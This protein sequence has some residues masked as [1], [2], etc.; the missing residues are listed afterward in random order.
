MDPK[1]AK[2]YY[3]IRSPQA[4]DKAL[5]DLFDSETG[6]WIRKEI[7]LVRSLNRSILLIFL[8]HRVELPCGTLSLGR[9]RSSGT[10]RDCRANISWT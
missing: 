2:A 1:T 8:F 5:G 3:I 10:S 4:I 7:E 9:G 6:D